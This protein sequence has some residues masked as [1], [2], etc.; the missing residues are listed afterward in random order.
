MDSGDNKKPFR[1]VGRAFLFRVDYFLIF[2]GFFSEFNAAES[3]CRSANGKERIESAAAYGVF[4]TFFG[5]GFFRLI[6]V[7]I[8]VARGSRRFGSN[9]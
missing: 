3:Y 1:V 8:A 2:F 7:F 6:V 5:R 4:T 9:L